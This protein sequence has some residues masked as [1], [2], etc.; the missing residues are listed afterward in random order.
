MSYVLYLAEGPSDVGLCPAADFV[1]TEAESETATV[2]FRCSVHFKRPHV[3]GKTGLQ[4]LRG[5]RGEQSLPILQRAAA[6]LNAAPEPDFNYAHGRLPE[7]EAR[8]ALLQLLALARQQP[9]GVWQV[10]TADWS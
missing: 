2:S 3:L 4:R 7:C 1:A 6:A 10:E 8:Q 5:L 9:Q